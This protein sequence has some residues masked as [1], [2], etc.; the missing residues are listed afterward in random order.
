MD[1]A[2]F[3]LYTDYLLSSFGRTTATGLSELV[4]GAVS[5][6]Q[7]TRSLA[8]Q[9]KTSADLWQYVKPLVRKVQSP[10]GVI[11]VDD[12][13]EEKPSTDLSELICTHYDHSKGTYVRGINFLTA[14]YRVEAP[15]TEWSLPVA[16]DLVKKTEIV[17]DKKTGK[18]KRQSKL[19][20]NER[21]REMLKACVKNEIPFRY[22]LNDVWYASADN[23]KFVKQE[24]DKD[25]VMPLKSN[26]KVALSKADKALGRYTAVETLDLEEGTR[27]EVYLEGVDFL[28]LLIRQVFTNGDGSQGTLYLV[29]SD[30]TLSYEQMTMIYKTRWKIEEYH[31][32]LKQNAS[33]AKSPTKTETTQ[34]NHFFA[35]VCAYVK[36]EALKQTTSLNHFALKSKLYLAALKSAFDELQRLHTLSNAHPYLPAA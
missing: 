35:S 23:M 21:Y 6:D 9:K 22:V 36:L 7:V 32:S 11:S 29:T 17:I 24:L 10:E 5:H 30:T 4:S 1:K 31:H 3:D 2:L 12:S 8:G 13:I 18:E 19:T 27:K 26:R 34:T 15:E 25:F 28:L 20:K 16:F 33:L 14:L